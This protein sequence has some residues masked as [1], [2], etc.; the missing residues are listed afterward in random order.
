MHDGKIRL[1]SLVV[2]LESIGGKDWT[3]F[4]AVCWL[5]G[6]YL[7]D[8]LKI[9]IG[10]VASTWGGT[11]IEAWSPPSVLKICHEPPRCVY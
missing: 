9:P 1:M 7:Y 10:L 8:E 6:K 4:S 2:P 11:P 5:C 3:Y